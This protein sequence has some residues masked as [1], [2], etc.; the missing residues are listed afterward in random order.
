MINS[1]T[2]VTSDETVLRRNPQN[3]QRRPGAVEWGDVSSLS[4]I[5]EMACMICLVI[6]SRSSP[7][8]CARLSSRARLGW[9]SGCCLPLSILTF[10]V[11][12]RSCCST[13][14]FWAFP[15]EEA[16]AAMSSTASAAKARTSFPDMSAKLPGNSIT[17]IKSDNVQKH[18]F[19][20]VTCSV[21]DESVKRLQPQLDVTVGCLCCT[22]SSFIPHLHY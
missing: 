4:S 11:L 6:I 1:Q 20:G 7:D 2:W 8:S 21:C 5:P 10:S 22:S 13:S 3:H 15:A 16:A 17:F 9:D 14:L 18:R 12:V 19:F